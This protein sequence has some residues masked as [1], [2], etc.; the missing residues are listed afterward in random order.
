MV[1]GIPVSFGVGIAR[2]VCLSAKET[3]AVHVDSQPANVEQELKKLHDSIERST[4]ELNRLH[5]QVSQEIGAAEAAILDAHLA[6]LQDPAFAGEMKTQ[7]QEQQLYA[8]QAVQQVMEHFAAIFES[9]DDSYMRERAADVRDVGKRMIK[10]INNP[11]G[12]AQEAYTEPFVLVAE[13]VTP[14][15]TISLPRQLVRAIVAAKGGATSHAAILARSL[16][17]PAVMGAG[18]E[19]L[20]QTANGD[21]VIVDG[22]SGSIHINPDE[23]TLA[24]YQKQAERERAEMEQLEKLR[25]LPAQTTDGRRI[26]LVANIGRPEETEAVLAKGAEGVGLFRS[27][28]LFMDREQLPT[29][30]E[31]F[32]AYRD[33]IS[34]MAGKPVIIRTLDVG[35][36]KHLPYLDMPKEENPFLGWR[37]IRISLDRIDL[38]K[39]QLRA[40]LR[41]SAFGKALIM[42]PMI[43]HV[44]QIRRAKGLVEEVKQELRQEGIAF[45]EAIPLGIMIEIPAACLIADALAA[46]VDFFSI[47]TNDLVQYTL[48]VDRMNER[49][50][51]LY[52]YFHPAVLRLIQ[53]VIDASHR[54]GIW[55]GMCGEMAADPLAAPLLLGMGLDE[56]SCNA[57]SL[58]RVKEQIRRMSYESAQEV[59]KNALAL[60]TPDEVKTYLASL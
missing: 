11:E 2:A 49:L 29:E 10:N 23:E 57:N 45:D 19:L 36:D 4:A 54:N 21:L 51:D 16:G 6:F 27:E 12:D 31:Q 9:L 18:P 47:G 13:D 44:E 42:F 5:E 14:S 59:A 26:E 30:E 20:T 28:F 43:S 25:D 33:A 55:T 56:F 38:F 8:V 1:K 34:G 58:P 15:D 22:T 35:G 41:A 3:Q 50:S 17:I 24:R 32:A 52:S 53:Q 37:A 46:E 39:E 40:I 60:S 48:A 7:I